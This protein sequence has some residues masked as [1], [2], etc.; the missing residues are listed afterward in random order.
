MFLSDLAA[1]Q[2]TQAG[3]RTGLDGVYVSAYLVLGNIF[4]R[5]HDAGIKDVNTNGGSKSTMN[6]A[7]VI[8][9]TAMM[10]D[11]MMITA[12]MRAKVQK[13]SVPFAV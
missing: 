7:S 5:Y 10:I 6:T 2:E 13:G 12:L 1:Q 4:E 3:Q 8:A 11:S 9:S